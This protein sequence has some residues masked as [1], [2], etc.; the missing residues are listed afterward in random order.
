MKKL[1][2]Y[3][4]RLKACDHSTIIERL[5][6]LDIRL[7]I[8]KNKSYNVAT[9][10]TGI[11]LPN[12]G[13]YIHHKWRTKRGWIKVSI[14]VDKHTKELLDIEVALDNVSDYKLAKKHLSNL[15]DVKINDF[16]GD[17]AYY[18]RELYDILEKKNITP[19][20]KMP[21]NAS[22][23]GFDSMHRAVRE[24]KKL[25]GYT[26]WKDK[27]KYGLRWNIE[28]YNSS[29]KRVF[30]ECVKM[31]KLQN[32]LKEAKYKFIN[33]ERMKKYALLKSQRALKI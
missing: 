1:S 17:G 11:K 13:E 19:I 30:G 20:I 25:G 2:K 4:P 33:Y 23:K 32:C 9:D 10:G 14:V 26:P 21:I 3:I 31:H 15:K 27:Y 29:T 5:N 22:Y 24:M 12:R 18:V 8:N 16:S 7:K 28:G 6:K